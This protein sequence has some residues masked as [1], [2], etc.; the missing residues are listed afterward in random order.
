MNT[1]EIESLLF[2]NKKTKHIFKGVFPSDRLPEVNNANRKNLVKK[3]SCFIF[4][5]DP[6]TKPGSHW[7]SVYLPKNRPA[8][9]FDSYGK[10]PGIHRNFKKFLL[11]NA[12]QHIF[13]KTQIQ[14]FTSDLCGQYCCLF[15]LNRCQ[16]KTMKQFLKKFSR[17][18]EHNDRLC[19]KMFKQNF[20]KR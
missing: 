4:N 11:K 8:E 9:Y 1:I 18:T 12:N 5:L 13:N 14:G 10:G 2:K 16:R 17:N 15:I 19:K 7:I 3:P 20:L 6:S